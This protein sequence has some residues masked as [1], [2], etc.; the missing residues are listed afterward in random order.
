[1]NRDSPTATVTFLGKISSITSA[2]SGGKTIPTYICETQ[3]VSAVQVG[4]GGY[5]TAEADYRF[6]DL[7]IHA[8]HMHA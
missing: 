7:V 5:R 6:S 8:V 2:C 1:M 3:R 4:N